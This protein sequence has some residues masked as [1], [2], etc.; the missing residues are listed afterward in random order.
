MTLDQDSNVPRSVYIFFIIIFI[1][2]TPVSIG[3]LIWPHTFGPSFFWALKPFNTRFLGFLYTAEMAVVFIMTYYRTWSPARFAMWSAWIFT[4]WATLIT[5][6]LFNQVVF[7][8]TWRVV[9]WFFLYLGSFLIIS[10][11]F[12]KTKAYKILQTVSL[13]L[14]SRFLL[15]FHTLILSFHAIGLIISP[16]S[17]SSDFW[18]LS[19]D[20]FSGRFYAGIFLLS[21]YGNYIVYKGAHWKEMLTYGVILIVFSFGVVLGLILVDHEVHKINW[22]GFNTWFWMISSFISGLM[23]IYWIRYSKH[24]RIPIN[25]NLAR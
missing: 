7:T 23:G 21:L 5:T 20:V 11:L 9:L 19:L 1:L 24:F 16:A 13:N 22:S 14:L 3:L 10:Y 18:P 8:K 2:V 25:S 17:F 4:G 6:I 12:T 15:I